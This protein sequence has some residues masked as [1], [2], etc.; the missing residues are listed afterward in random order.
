MQR[1]SHVEEVSDLAKR[2]SRLE[3]R[4][5]V[6]AGLGRGTG[7]GLEPGNE[8]VEGELL[9]ES[10]GAGAG[11]SGRSRCGSGCG[12]GR[13]GSRL[14]GRG[15]G[16]SGSGGSSRLG[17]AGLGGSS[18]G[19]TVPDLGAGHLVGGST[20][21]DVEQNTGVRGGVGLGHIH[22]G[23]GESLGT[24]ASNLDLTAAVVELGTLGAVALVESNHLG[25]DQ[26]L[27]SGEAGKSDAVLALVG[28]EVLNSPLAVG[29][30]ISRDLGPDGTLTVGLGRGNVDHDG[31]LVRG[32]DGLISITR[33]GSRVV[34]VPLEGD[35]R[36]TG[37]LKGIGSLD[38]TVAGHEVGADIQDRVVAVGRSA[39][40]EVVT[41]VLAINDERLEGGVGGS[42][43]GSS[44]SESVRVLH[45]D[46]WW[47][48]GCLWRRNWYSQR[49]EV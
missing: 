18:A 26:V 23:S 2:A 42:Q 44:Q 5:G 30:T 16:L 12:S 47:L 19:D 1:P 29:K 3:E 36:V 49:M 4:A 48:V 13:R 17:S 40:S 27:T 31:A 43:L 11:A 35:L 32:S 25:A 21:V 10:G 34:V 33:D 38:T 9:G 45:F 46:G 6:A 15:G 14:G 22:A 39:D 24:G 41:L 37:N 8:L 20:T 7:G 28:D